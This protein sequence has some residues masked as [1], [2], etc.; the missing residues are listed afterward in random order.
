VRFVV[1]DR[2]QVMGQYTYSPFGE[3]YQENGL[4][5]LYRYAGEPWSAEAGL[6]YLRAR[7][8]DPATGRFLTRD[9]FSGFLD[10]PQT[11][12]PYAYATN[13][14]INLTDPSGLMPPDPFGADKGRMLYATTAM[15]G[16]GGGALYFNSLHRGQPV[17]VRDALNYVA[18]G[19]FIGMTA[20]TGYLIAP[21]IFAPATAPEVTTAGEIAEFEATTAPRMF[22]NTTQQCAPVVGSPTTES[23]A[24]TPFQA[25]NSGGYTVYRYIDASGT[26]RYIGMT[27]DFD[28]RAAEH[29]AARGWRIVRIPGL[30]NVGKLDARAA[31]Q[32]LI[33][34]YGLPRDGGQLYNQIFSISPR[35]PVYQQAILRGNEILEWLG[36]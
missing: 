21:T 32:V 19:M 7:H 6:T 30:D 15:G 18:W 36:Y 27:K 22:R 29:L 8:Y 2:R 9:S 31:E 24:L 17:N 25:I 28:R 20:G 26:V 11:L 23:M 34:R 12:N 13:N 10:M 4:S 33:E 3:P 1:N 14:P 5:P 35:N 16:L